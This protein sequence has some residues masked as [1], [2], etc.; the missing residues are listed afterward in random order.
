MPRRVPVLDGF[1]GYAILGV[2][3]LHL[4]LLSKVAAP[5][6]HVSLV[7]WGVFGNIIDTFF[8][9][10]GFVIFLPV[11]FREG[12]LGSIRSFALGR[13]VRILP[14]YW[15][16]IAVVI[17]LLVVVPGQADF[18]FLHRLPEILAD[19]AAIQ[20][21]IRLFDGTFQVGL[22]INGSLWMISVIVGFYFVFPFIARAYYRHPLIGLGIAAGITLG[23]KL[24]VLHVPGVFGWLDHSGEATWVSQLIAVDQLPG[25]AFSFGLGM[26]GAWAYVEIGKRD[27]VG[28]LREKAP[29][30]AAVSFGVCAICAYAYARHASNADTGIIGGSSARENPFLT[31]AL[32]ASRAALMASIILSPLWLQRLFANRPA[33][34]IAELSYGIYLIHLVVAWYVGLVWLDLPRDGSLKAALLWFGVVLPISIAYAWGSRRFVELP[35]KRWVLSVRRGRAPALAPSQLQHSDA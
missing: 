5:G 8:I 32:S 26:T 21:P 30:A 16:S 24:A 2:V 7:S 28:R 18:R 22:G 9:I 3:S 1:R 15:L 4:L 20:M 29:I 17:L 19:M 31:M 6:T 34:R 25:W 27:L 13:A 33:A 12:R 23:W 35:V 10:S 11:V 14:A